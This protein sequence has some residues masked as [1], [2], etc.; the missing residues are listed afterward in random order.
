MLAKNLE[1]LGLTAKEAKVYLALLELGEAN[2]QNI[3]KKSKVKRT[4]V[5]DVIDSLREKGL[6]GVTVSRKKVLYF[7]ENPQLILNKIEEKEKIARE[8][9]PELMS[10]ANALEKKP[11]IRFFEGDEGIKEVY[12]DTLNYPGEELL[13]WV[14]GE[15]VKSFDKS[16]LNEYYLPQRI[17]KKIWV[18]AIAVDDEVMRQYK[19]SDQKFLRK[20]RLISSKEFPFVVEI[21]LYGG[22]KIAI[23]S[24][25]EKIS[26]IIESQKIY[27]TLK[28]IFELQWCSLSKK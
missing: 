14:T 8:I 25:K 24:F 16:F 3:S 20:T 27:T 21:N 22:S 1:K 19:E 18:R 5:Y 23:M 17:K 15:A 2:I 28:S 4:T 26:L 9:M 13:A 6:V 7:A 10:I 11:K 12:L